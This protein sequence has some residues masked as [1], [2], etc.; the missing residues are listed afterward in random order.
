[1]K[2][3]NEHDGWDH[4]G[5][6]ASTCDMQRTCTCCCN[7]G[8]SQIFWHAQAF[9]QQACRAQHR[10]HRLRRDPTSVM[11]EREVARSPAHRC[12]PRWSL[13]LAGWLAGR[14]AGRGG[15]SVGIYNFHG[16]P[17]RPLCYSLHANFAA[18]AR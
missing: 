2:V 6:E 12:P 10:V 13:R 9:S 14:R 7:G 17:L 4:E 3:K 16:K 18:S 15:A 1:M 11:L 5:G 8:T